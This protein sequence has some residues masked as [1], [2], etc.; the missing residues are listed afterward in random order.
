MMMFRFSYKNRM[1]F[2]YI[3]STALLIFAVFFVIYYTVSM[4]VYNHVNQDIES[5]VSKHLS[6]IEIKNGQIRLLHHNEWLE[7]EH[8]TVAVNP[9]FVQF[10]NSNKIVV[11]K[12]PNLNQI[13]LQFNSKYTENQLFNTQL[14]SK[15]IRQIQVPIY[16]KN[17]KMGYLLVAMSLEEALMVLQNLSQILILAY[18]LILILLFFIA[19]F[20]TGKS[21]KPVQTIIDTSKE[22]TKDNLHKRIKLPDNKDELYILSHTIND[23]LDRIENAIIREKQFTSDASHE[24]RTPLTIIKGTL[25]VLVRKPRTQKEYEEKIT[26]S[27]TEID[28]LNELITELLFLARVEN[29]L[30]KIDN[31]LF[32]INAVVSDY[33]SRYQNKIQTKEIQ[34]N[35]NTSQDFK[36]V[37]DPYWVAICIKNIL[38]NAIKYSKPQAAITISVRETP[39]EHELMIAD[40]GIGIK[41]SDLEKIF[42]PFFRSNAIENP[43]I[44]GSGLGLSIVKKICDLLQ[45][46]ISIHSVENQGTT[47]KLHFKK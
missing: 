18:P 47:I 22:I 20:I 17:Q 29:H 32:S 2:Y 25:E 30:Q 3:L 44:K 9:V 15:K 26:F 1:A 40:N 16:D 8:N 24:L 21:I 34:I 27:I 33:L 37:S 31:Q 46:K 41:S 7:R 10:M 14:A 13:E 36:V 28:R 35:F 45:I 11:E 6:E 5:E 19:R 38:S 12:S 39:Q 23:L 42:Q 4:S 43:D